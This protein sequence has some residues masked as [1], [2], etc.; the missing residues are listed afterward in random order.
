MSAINVTF[1]P[2][3]VSPPVASDS[4]IPFVVGTAPVVQTD[5]LEK[6]RPVLCNTL[7]EFTAA[8]G[9]AD[10][11]EW[12]DYTLN[13]AAA[14]WFQLY[15]RAPFIA[16][17]VV[18]ITDASHHKTETSEAQTLAGP[19]DAEFITLDE[20]NAILSTIVVKD[21]TDVTTYVLTTDYTVAFDSTAGNYG[22]VIIS[23]VV[24]GALGATDVLHVTYERLDPTGID[25]ADLIG[26]VSGV[27]YK[28]WEVVNQVFPVLLKVP[29]ILMCPKWSKTPSIAAVMV[30][31]AASINGM[32]KA[33]ALTDLE[34]DTAEIANYTNVAAWI[35]AEGYTSPHQI[36]TWPTFVIDGDDYNSSSHM[37][38]ML[39]IQDGSSSLPFNSTHGKSLSAGVSLTNDDGD[40]IVLEPSQ[41]D[42]IKDAGAHTALNF[43][44][45]YTFWGTHTGAYPG[46]TDVVE[47]SQVVT[48][49]Q[50]WY[51]NALIL[52]NWQKLGDPINRRT[53]Q[54]I[55]DTEQQILN[56]LVSQGALLPGAAITFDADLNP[57]TSLLA[58]SVTYSISWTVPI[59]LEQI[60]FQVR[61]DAAGLA[62]LF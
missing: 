54:S 45:G 21:A 40:T 57:D 2:S 1:L 62:G 41:A 46:S 59:T 18:D 14:A 9:Q 56:G 5:V 10:A 20:K 47:A 30:A 60:N 13:E 53:A 52:R 43:I 51:N 48:R 50:W 11:D 28:G 26:S 31:K 12:G 29:S 7:G 22:D 15:A 38:P 6:N 25:A 55:V 58:G 36:N 23:R 42:T 3:S 32:F 49:M 17:N 44:G 19:T 35:V 34:T 16:S 24:G 4:A 39:S 33:C 37:G 8:F 61:Y 27:T